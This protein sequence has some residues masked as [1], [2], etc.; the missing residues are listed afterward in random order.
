MIYYRKVDPTTWAYLSSLLM[1]GLFFKFNR[2]WSVRNLDLVLLILLAPGLL[3]VHLGRQQRHAAA[4]ADKI[5]AA[6]NSGQLSSG[7]ITSSDDAN[8]APL[9]ISTVDPSLVSSPYRATSPDQSPSAAL[10][11]T[12]SPAAGE[13]TDFTAP[14]AGDATHAGGEQKL[15]VPSIPQSLGSGLLTADDVP[16]LPEEVSETRTGE[17]PA[18]ALSPANVTD[19]VE[20]P[21]TES[22]PP[23]LVTQ[24]PVTTDSAVGESAA[25]SSTIVD[26]PQAASAGLE[27]G[28]LPA[29]AL[30]QQA[31]TA[32]VI[33]LES[34]GSTLTPDDE[35]PTKQRTAKAKGRAMEYFGYIW[36]FSVLLVL[37]I[38][39]LL[40]PT[41]VRRPLLE[42][43][44]TSGGL[45]FIG[46][47][48]FLFLMA[49]VIA[50]PLTPDE[51]RGARGAEALLTRHDTASSGGQT[52]EDYRRHG[53]GY[54]LLHV[55]P[56]IA[57]MPFVA[58]SDDRQIVAYAPAAKTM[59]I[60]AHL[61]VVAGLVVIG[62]WH[63]ENIKMG[64]GAATL[65]LMLPYTAQMT[66]HVDHVL[67]AALLMWAI[68]LYRRPAVAGILIGL[69]MGV[70]YYPLFLLPLWI[71]FYWQRGVGRFLAGVL[72]SI[73]VIALSLLFVSEDFASYFTRLQ[74]MFGLWMPVTRGLDGIW[75]LGWDPYY[76]LPVI[77]ACVAMSGGLAIWPA[78]KNLGTLLSCS[79][80]MMVAV[81]FWHG[82]GGGLYLAWFLPLLLLTIFRPNLEDRVAL[83]V[84]GE[85]WFVRRRMK[86]A[87][88]NRAA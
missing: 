23:K 53:P 47:A 24:K 8:P 86:L 52:V 60:L 73:S 29:G 76:R 4:A 69:A 54:S 34:D 81:Q 30:G 51:L 67:P 38:R 48:L 37:L 43:N 10:G 80:A 82:Y 85:G 50:S 3:M 88:I 19:A 83:T 42:P 6:I 17:S 22:L 62:Y 25:T 35:Q 75:G 15:T 1:I 32:S 72:S 66:G 18:S 71:S 13:S 20:P 56:S 65:Y 41:M 59:A 68:V 44:L 63:F 55:L 64:I 9:A 31:S 12:I 39:L 77:A 61:A 79:A 58:P 87:Q 49:N 11:D 14:G 70:L 40:D 74:Q 7:Q 36:L 16:N 26:A 27:S 84:L 46:C 2:F 28:A 21:S 78:Q 33:P 45:L 5:S 57:T